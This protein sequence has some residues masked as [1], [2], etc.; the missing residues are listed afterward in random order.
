ME[1]A[2]EP[3]PATTAKRGR[4]KKTG[5]LKSATSFRLSAQARRILEA[6]SVDTG[7]SQASV[8]EQALRDMAKRRGVKVEGE[9]AST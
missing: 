7:I 1:T 2:L 9:G 4:P 8:V 6:L 3:K 5:P